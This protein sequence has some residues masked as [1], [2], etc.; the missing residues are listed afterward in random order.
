MK[1]LLL[2]VCCCLYLPS[3]WAANQNLNQL[4]QLV[5][6]FA[7]MNLNQRPGVSFEL[8]HFDRRL[9][10]P[11]CPAPQ[12]SW[13]E[14]EPPADSGFV[15]V[16]CQEP[17]WRVR[18]PIRVNEARMGLVLTHAVR[19]GD[20]LS[21]DD[22]Q[23]VAIPDPRTNRDVLNSPSQAVGQTMTSGAVAG[24]WLRSFMVKPPLVVKMNQRVRIVA[25]GVGFSV[26]A[27]GV[28]TAN[29]RAGDVVAVRMPNGQLLRGVVSQD[30]TVS[31]SN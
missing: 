27:E 30:G 20:I 26:E 8:G 12:T 10:L 17:Y 18:L 31:V 13:P 25:A 19:A 24:I 14:G 3:C 9:V 28:A 5:R 23:L 15:D 21:A 4:E 22:V 6:R 11:Q 16:S 29:G 2:L 7:Q 1:R